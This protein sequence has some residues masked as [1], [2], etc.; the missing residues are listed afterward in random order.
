MPCLRCGTV[1][2]LG[3]FQQISFP[4]NGALC[5][6]S[7]RR[8]MKRI[9]AAGMSA[10]RKSGSGGKRPSSRRRSDRCRRTTATQSPALSFTADSDVI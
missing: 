1:K 10:S 7:N 5:R 4:A 8:P 3:K 9:D 2:V 6:R